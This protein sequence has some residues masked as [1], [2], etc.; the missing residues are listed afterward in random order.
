MMRKLK[1]LQYLCGSLQED[2]GAEKEI[3][4]LSDRMKIMMV[5]MR[6]VKKGMY[7]TTSRNKKNDRDVAEGEDVGGEV[8]E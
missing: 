5:M 1:Q 4:H 7:K 2:G 8:K 3:G 6:Q